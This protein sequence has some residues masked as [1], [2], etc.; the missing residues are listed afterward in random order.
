MLCKHK[1]YKSRFQGLC[2]SL[3][4]LLRRAWG[5]GNTGRHNNV[6]IIGMYIRFQLVHCCVACVN[7]TLAV[8]EYLK[9]PIF[10]LAVNVF[11]NRVS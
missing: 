3:L 1:L 6:R 8:I 4:L 11:M 5:W 10:I 2:F 7:F 9:T